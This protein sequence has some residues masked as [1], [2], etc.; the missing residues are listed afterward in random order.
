MIQY[1]K[2]TPAVVEALKH[3][4]GDKY[5]ITDEEK[6]LP[7]SHDEVTD[8]RYHHMPEVVVLPRTAQEI[9]E[10]VKLANRELI[11]IVPRGAGTGLACGAVPV[12]GGIVLS[13]ERMNSILELNTDSLYMVVEPGIRTD[14][15]QNAAREAGL[16]YA[17]DPCSGDSC[18]IGGNVATNA[19]GNRAVKY[20]TTRDQVY[21]IEVVTPRGDIVT[22]G[23]RL[24][25]VTT[26]YRLDQLI[27]GSEGTLGIITKITLKLMPLPQ[28]VVDLLAVFPDI[29]TAIGLVPKLIK[30]GITP[31]CVEFMDNI[32]IRSVERFL[33]EKLPHSENGH[34]V[35]VQVEGENE[36]D[37]DNKS[38]L[39]DE[40]CTEH[41]AMS[42]L[43]ADPKK[44]WRARK[45]FAEAVRHESLIQA[46]EDIV[47]PV[48][49]IPAMMREIAVLSEKYGLATRTASHAGDGN[50][51]LNILKGDMPDGEW[52]AKLDAFQH[53][54]YKCV[55]RLG[56]K[57]SGEHGIGYKRKQLMQEFTDPVELEMMRAIKK[58]LD[59]NLI[60]NPGKIFDV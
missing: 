1:N 56:G 12:H 17:G 33:N 55:Y 4:V 16:F 27:I 18:F 51:H 38:V 40:L 19:G 6:M 42:V 44:I 14:D 23:G 59:P 26:G 57:L 45:S 2:V 48:D 47:V 37:L 39:L 3:I 11:P 49:Q 50:I 8:S 28:H 25:K 5:V 13:L 32:T 58:A 7:Y 21:A 29:D 22:L 35:I 41:G 34:Y 43:V 60:L 54:L 52:D 24:E 30:A 9:A 53:E 15:V 10:I 20:G 31:T 36:D 46:K